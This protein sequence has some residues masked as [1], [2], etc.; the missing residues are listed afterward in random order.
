MDIKG[1]AFDLEGT[2]VNLEPLHHQ[3]WLEVANEDLGLEL[4][5]EVIMQKIPRFI[6]GG[7]PKIAEGFAAL[8]GKNAD[9]ILA[10]NMRRYLK[11]LK[12]AE[13]VPRQ[14]FV[15]FLAQL[16]SKGIPIAIGSLTQNDLAW[17][18]I[19]ASGLD[20]LFDSQNIVLRDDADA[21]KPAPDVYLETARRLNIK[22]A[23]QVV[24]ED[25]VTGVEA[26][27]AA[28]SVVIGMPIYLYYELTREQLFAAGATAIYHSWSD[29][30]LPEL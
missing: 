23:D 11:R 27:V 17:H 7:D 14:G 28:G 18:L 4:T 10:A 2:I 25:S 5:L 22:P 20:L 24:F 12:K 6:G 16:Q 9:D 15:D 13:I 8:T 29:V 1:A 3:S 19:K 30:L 26:G 21:V